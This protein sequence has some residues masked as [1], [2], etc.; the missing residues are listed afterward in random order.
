MYSNA[1]QRKWVDQP[2][3]PCHLAEWETSG[4]KNLTFERHFDKMEQTEF[5]EEKV[6]AKKY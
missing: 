1:Y 2:T 3:D 4:D 5:F 6:E